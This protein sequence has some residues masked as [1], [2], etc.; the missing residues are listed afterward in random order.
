MIDDKLL[1]LG[2]T[3][4]QVAEITA[5]VD[6]SHAELS[7]DAVATIL[8]RLLVRLDKDSI[9]GRALARSLGFGS[10]QSLAR[11]AGEFG[12]SKQ[13]LHRLESDLRERVDGP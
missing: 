10:E 8:R 4:E 11:A 2:Y 13:Y 12:V 9:A 6:A 5:L 7:R 3:P 1:E